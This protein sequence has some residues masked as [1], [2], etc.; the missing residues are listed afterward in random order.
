MNLISLILG[1]AA[2]GFAVYSAKAKGCLSC[3]TLS[4][5][6]CSAS[7]LCQLLDNDRLA[8]LEDICAILDT[9]HARA[10]CA[11][12]LLILTSVLNILALLR[13]RQKNQKTR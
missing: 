8:Q 12:V 9:A 5:L 4:G 1:F 13:N 10:V 2:L 7:L 11:A 3:T 6:C